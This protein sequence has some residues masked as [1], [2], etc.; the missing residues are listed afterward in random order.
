[1]NKQATSYQS[2]NNSSQFVL[3]EGNVAEKTNFVENLNRLISHINHV[4][5]YPTMGSYVEGVKQLDAMLEAYKDAKFEDDYNQMDIFLSKKSGSFTAEDK[6]NWY[7]E[8]SQE[9]ARLLFKILM[10]LM[11]RSGLSPTGRISSIDIGY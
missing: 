5:V 11:S 6:Y 7:E 8:N 4:A 3:E 9:I 2:K 10:K 1:M